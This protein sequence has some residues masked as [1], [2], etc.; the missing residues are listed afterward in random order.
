LRGLR[1]LYLVVATG[2]QPRPDQTPGLHGGEWRR[3]IH[4]FYAY[5]GAL[6]LARALAGFTGGRRA[7]A[8]CP[9]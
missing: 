1:R 4:D 6:A 2:V 9:G 8:G 3:S 5:D 7:S